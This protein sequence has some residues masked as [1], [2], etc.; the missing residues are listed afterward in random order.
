MTLSACWLAP[1]LLLASLAG[2]TDLSYFRDPVYP[3]NN[4]VIGSGYPDV[5]SH[6]PLY[7]RVERNSTLLYDGPVNRGMLSLCAM[8]KMDNDNMIRYSSDPMGTSPSYGFW[9][10]RERHIDQVLARQRGEV[11]ELW[12]HF[13]YLF[14]S[15]EESCRI[16]LPV[17]SS[18][19]VFETSYSFS[20]STEGSSKSVP[21]I[22][23][24]DNP[25][26]LELTRTGDP[27]IRLDGTWLTQV[28][29]RASFAPVRLVTEDSGD[30]K[31]GD[32]EVAT[33]I[34]LDISVSP[35]GAYIPLIR[36]RYK[37]YRPTS[38]YSPM[39]VKDTSPITGFPAD[40]ALRSGGKS[41]LDTSIIC[42]FEVFY[43]RS[44]YSPG[45]LPWYYWLFWAVSVLLGIFFARNEALKRLGCGSAT[46]GF[47]F[48]AH[49]ETYVHLLFNLLGFVGLAL[50][51]GLLVDTCA[52][53][54]LP[55]ITISGL[56]FDDWVNL[57]CSL[58]S[59][60][61]VLAYYLY[62]RCLQLS[63][64]VCV[65]DWET[66]LRDNKRDELIVRYKD[67]YR[68]HSLDYFSE[69]RKLAAVR[70]LAR[71]YKRAY[72][73][74]M[75][76]TLICMIVYFGVDVFYMSSGMI[77]WSYSPAYTHRMF[78]V[79]IYILCYLGTYLC[80]LLLTRMSKIFF[81]SEF[82]RYGNYLGRLNCSV[83]IF[84]S[85]YSAHYIHGRSQ[86]ATSEVPLSV[87]LDAL[88]L[89]E[90]GKLAPA[91]LGEGRQLYFRMFVGPS[92]I[93]PESSV[94]DRILTVE[95]KW[96]NERPKRRARALA[97]AQQGGAQPGEQPGGALGDPQD[98]EQQTGIEAEEQFVDAQKIYL[99]KLFYPERLLLY[100]D[101][102]FSAKEFVRTWLAPADIRDAGVF[103]SYFDLPPG[104]DLGQ[105]IAL[106]ADPAEKKSF[107]KSGSLPDGKGTMPWFG[108]LFPC[109]LYIWE[110]VLLPLLVILLDAMFKGPVMAM[111]LAVGV[112]IVLD[113]IF[114]GAWTRKLQAQTLIHKNY[115]A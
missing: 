24:N 97:A 95:R 68:S 80:L 12:P 15:Y 84:D 113:G 64:K 103:R 77:D 22:V 75:A 20:V 69:W 114:Y 100:A 59:A 38:T 52:Y 78:R 6:I 72:V 93:P 49:K 57:T 46:A 31:A 94:Y 96:V 83:L 90:M 17:L 14:N 89:Q 56:F 99:T 104:G 67:R 11:G 63:S 110:G 55:D 10:R 5:P 53:A 36:V 105:G 35:A 86:I 87:H 61:F 70:G 60:V 81:K 47:G 58:I 13:L 8:T 54:I 88:Q 16:G 4:Y 107:G 42:R 21:V 45:V 112:F 48:L 18:H 82:E 40:L 106:F 39:V 101:L 28:E 3:I 73:S 109:R 115:F 91:G 37:H 29:T 41:F 108:S 32:I 50:F 43:H 51:L 23:E 74:R 9:R 66:E 62:R 102:H 1:W 71:L 33:R 65:I 26:L 79:F 27:Y 19:A 111:V 30:F 44:Y 34:L 85:R 2:A 7:M 25:A 92:A 98:G 76:V